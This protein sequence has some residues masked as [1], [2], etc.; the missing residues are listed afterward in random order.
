M[1]FL[2]S[3]A[4]ALPSILI[5]AMGRHVIKRPVRMRHM[6]KDVV[7]VSIAGAAGR[8][9]QRLCALA[10]EVQGV[11]LAEAFERAGH[12]AVGRPAVVDG[13]LTIADGCNARGNVLIDFTSPD[14]TPDLL[15][16]CVR[17]GK[18]MVIGTTGLDGE[19]QEAIDTAAES[20]AIVQAPNMSLGVNILFNL[21][22]QVAKQL[23][24]EYDIEVLE[25]HH[26]HK[27]D[28]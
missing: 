20:I 3:K 25:S 28:A 1:D 23:G 15:E 8:M 10:S 16:A 11:E 2:P 24:D 7:T 27:K 14:A 6:A 9:G 12:E 19:D 13:R 21:A 17:H 26:R 5:L 22:A 4:Q 18:A